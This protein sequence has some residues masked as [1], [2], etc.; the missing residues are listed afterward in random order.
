MYISLLAYADRQRATTAFKDWSRGS[1]GSR[2]MSVPAV[3]NE[4]AAVAQPGAAYATPSTEMTVRVGTVIVRMTYQDAR[5]NENSAQVL[6]ALARMQ[7]QRLWQ[8]EEGQD[9]SA[10]A[11]LG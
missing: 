2:P 5:K 7:A 8:A 1:V 3:G 9:P 6:L 11:A 4:S 10:T